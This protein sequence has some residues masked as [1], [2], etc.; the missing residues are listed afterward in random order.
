MKIVYILLF[1]WFLVGLLS[2]LHFLVNDIRG[3]EYDPDYFDSDLLM[4]FLVSVV[5]GYLTTLLILY[6]RQVIQR[7]LYKLANIGYKERE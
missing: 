1:S 7:I 5:F 4:M 6:D 3:E 2:F